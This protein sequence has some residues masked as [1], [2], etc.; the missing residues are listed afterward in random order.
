MNAAQAA[1]IARQQQLRAQQAAALA[2]QQQQMGMMGMPTPQMLQQQLYQLQM[3]LQNPQLPP[4][5]RMQVM[6]Q[7][8]QCQMMGVQMGLFPGQQGQGQQGGQFAGRQQQQQQGS[9][10]PQGGGFGRATP[11]AAA[12][13][14]PGGVGGPIPTGPKAAVAGTNGAAS[15][16]GAAGAKR[17]APEEFGAN[18][19]AKKA[20]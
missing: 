4:P 3:T 17:G 18:G 12:Q 20:A 8:Q 14:R 13:Q 2:H 11:L 10:S 9:M 16:Q 7:L 6:Q 15:P 5:M 19:S 1:Q